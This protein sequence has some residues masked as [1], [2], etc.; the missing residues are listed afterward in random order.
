MAT[1]HPTNETSPLLGDRN[2]EPL[3]GQ[4]DRDTPENVEDVDKDERPEP[5]TQADVI[6]YGILAFFI[7]VTGISIF[8]AL[9]NSPDS[10][11]GLNCSEG[12]ILIS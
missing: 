5:W 1:F 6:K 10:K 2:N 7:I 3:I 8:I 11:V 12:P 4:N 9:R